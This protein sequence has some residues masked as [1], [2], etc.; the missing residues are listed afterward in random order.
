MAGSVTAPLLHARRELAVIVHVMSD[1]AFKKYLQHCTGSDL[2]LLRGLLLKVLRQ[3][4]SL[5]GYSTA[6]AVRDKQLGNRHVHGQTRSNYAACSA[7][8]CGD[9]TKQEH[10]IQWVPAG[11]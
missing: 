9:F 6:A 7:S 2:M 4:A 1:Y 11:M 8:W 10:A 5:Q 3:A